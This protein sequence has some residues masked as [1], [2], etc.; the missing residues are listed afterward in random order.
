MKVAMKFYEGKKE[1]GSWDSKTPPTNFRASVTS[2]FRGDAPN[3]TYSAGGASITHRN[4]R[5]RDPGFPP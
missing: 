3:I 2:L 4:P 1:I 5:M